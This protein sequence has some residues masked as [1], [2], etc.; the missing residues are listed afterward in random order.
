ML[1]MRSRESFAVL[2]DHNLQPIPSNRLFSSLAADEAKNLPYNK[3][4]ADQRRKYG[5][6][7]LRKSEGHMT[8]QIE[9]ER[10]A[11]AA[12]ESAK[13]LQDEKTQLMQAKLVGLVAHVSIQ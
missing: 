3:E 9:Y 4:I 5:E 8:L 6:S 1:N 12:I 7:M 10:K 13:R 2:G 11:Q